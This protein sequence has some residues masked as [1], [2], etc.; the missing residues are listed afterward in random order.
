MPIFYDQ[1]SHFQRLIISTSREGSEKTEIHTFRGQFS[2]SH[3][4]LNDN[5]WV[6]NST[7][8]ALLGPL[9]PMGQFRP[10]RDTQGD[11]PVLLSL[12]SPRYV[13]ASCLW[14][15]VFPPVDDTSGQESCFICMSE[16]HH[17]AQHRWNVYNKWTKGARWNRARTTR[18][19]HRAPEAQ[20]RSPG[21]SRGRAQHQKRLRSSRESLNIFG[22]REI[23]PKRKTGT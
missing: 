7:S 12:H 21:R 22:K 18:H 10:P 17:R 9:L 19:A 16:A 6:S 11:Q 14:I 13:A 5:F 23:K 3:E 2:G 8:T 15:Y 20:S 1:N 4:I